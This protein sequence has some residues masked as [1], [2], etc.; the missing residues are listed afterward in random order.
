MS[1]SDLIAFFVDDTLKSCGAVLLLVVA[2]KLHKLKC[3]STSS[4]GRY[5]SMHA[6]NPSGT[7]DTNEILDQVHHGQ[8]SVQLKSVVLLNSP[9]NGTS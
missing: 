3:D 2:Y 8:N 5:F 1:T 4:C 9:Q 7:A 6:S